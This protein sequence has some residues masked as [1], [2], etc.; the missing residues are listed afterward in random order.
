MLIARVAEGRER[1]LTVFTAY[2]MVFMCQQARLG[3]STTAFYGRC[4]GIRQK[5]RKRA[6]GALQRVWRNFI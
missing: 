2:D 1:P 3:A 6:R 4:I 5:S